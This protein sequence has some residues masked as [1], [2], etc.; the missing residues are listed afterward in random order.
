MCQDLS[1]KGKATGRVDSKR[2]KVTTARNDRENVILPR[3]FHHP[4]DER[5][6]EK[7]VLSARAAESSTVLRS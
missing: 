5:T 6:S 3:L 7:R 1:G 4:A 2:G